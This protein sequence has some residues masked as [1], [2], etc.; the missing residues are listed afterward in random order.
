ML[1]TIANLKKEY[2]K[3]KVLLDFV[4][5]IFGLILIF[6]TFR[7]IVMNFNN[8]A[9]LKNLRDF[10]LPIFFTITF[11]PFVYVMAL[12]MQYEILF[13]RM[14]I[15]NA[16]PDLA[17]YARRKIY[18]TCHINLWKLNKLA[19]KK[20]YIMVSDHDDVIAQLKEL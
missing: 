9:T 17:K 14:N 19:N 16:N 18:A 4:L 3:M 5:A 20:G 12:Y 10:L 1:H 13:V 6:F 8:F 11:S 7:E 2:K 15:R